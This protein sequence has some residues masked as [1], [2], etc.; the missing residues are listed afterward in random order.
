MRQETAKDK[1]H[2]ADTIHKILGP[3]PG[4]QPKEKERDKPPWTW[5]TPDT[6]TNIPEVM[7]DGEAVEVFQVT[8]GTVREMQNF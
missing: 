8:V 3:N 4:C 1:E 5:D 2:M 7:M 6:K